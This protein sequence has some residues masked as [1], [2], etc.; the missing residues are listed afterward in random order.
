MQITPANDHLS[1]YQ[2]GP[3]KAYAVKTG[4]TENFLA[5]KA[6][7]PPPLLPQRSFHNTQILDQAVRHRYHL[8]TTIHI[9]KQSGTALDIIKFASFIHDTLRVKIIA[10]KQMMLTLAENAPVHA[11]LVLRSQVSS[12]DGD[13]WR[14]V[15]PAVLWFVRS[16][17]APYGSALTLRGAVGTAA[18]GA[19]RRRRRL[20]YYI[21]SLFPLFIG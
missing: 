19:A 2:L 17:S 3:F 16:R 18:S 21:W 10:I 6:H 14:H 5:I 11:W 9:W 13:G 15:W 7:T 8:V 4:T 1:Q 20:F 12:T